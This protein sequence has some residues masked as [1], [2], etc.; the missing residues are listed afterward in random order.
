[1]TVVSTT[2]DDGSNATVTCPGTEIA[3]GGGV[4]PGNSAGTVRYTNPAS[5]N[6]NRAHGWAAATAK[7][8]NGGTSTVYVLCA[9]AS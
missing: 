5:I 6:G 8:G 7:Q 3:V 1:V 4:A 2:F 9:P